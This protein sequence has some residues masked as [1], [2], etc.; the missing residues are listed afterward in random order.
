MQAKEFYFL[1]DAAK[2]ITEKTQQ[3][4]TD[5][6]L[7]S[8]AL[9]RK[10]FLHISTS[11]WQV[12]ILNT[13][14]VVK[15]TDHVPIDCDMVKKVSKDFREGIPQTYAP[16][17]TVKTHILL[18]YGINSDSEYTLLQPVELD[19]CPFST[20]DLAIRH[21]DLF[22]FINQL[23]PIS[24]LDIGSNTDINH[25]TTSLPEKNESKNIFRKNET[26]T[27]NI[28]FAELD[29][30]DMPHYLGFNYIQHLLMNPDKQ[31]RAVE[32]NSILT[33]HKESK[34]Q[35]QTGEVISEALVNSTII[36]SYE[37]N[38]D[39]K[40]L[41]QFRQ[42]VIELQENIEEAHQLDDIE[43]AKKLEAEMDFISTE[44][45]KNTDQRGNVKSH[46]Q[47]EKKIRDTVA[48]NIKNARLKLHDEYPDL[49]DH[50]E[51]NI[52]TGKF[53]IYKSTEKMSWTFY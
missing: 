36:G 6:D 21:D 15:F 26:G 17:S 53:C 14:T 1:D 3:T 7:I 31:I 10:L 48:R 42:R 32:L 30:I 20:S 12:K 19:S 43:A 16:G 47:D 29:H 51:K 2:L 44:I 24:N 46:N 9:E 39:K 33:H 50:L 49:A 8:K 22:D 5:S 38:I 45:N 18:K 4:Y 27:W 23:C 52:S 25:I 41:E 34:N 11:N 28:K 13:N 40:A 37:Q 35:P